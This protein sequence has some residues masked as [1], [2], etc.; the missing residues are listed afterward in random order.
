MINNINNNKIVVFDLDETLGSFVELGIFWDA[1]ENFYGHKMSNDDF[2]TLLD[3]FIEFLRPDII[4]ILKFIINKRNSGECNK[5]M[6]YTNNQAPK[7]WTKLICNYFDKKLNTIVFDKIISAFKVNGKVV[8]ICRKSHNKTFG[9]LINCSK[10]PKNT[11]IFFI[12]DQLHPD[13][14]HENVYYIKIKPYNYSLPY[15]IMAE[16]YYEYEYNNINKVSNKTEF[17][18][19]IIKIMN[20]YNYIHKDINSNE[21]D[22]IVSKQIMNYLKEFFL[23]KKHNTLKKKVIKLKKNKT[24]KIKII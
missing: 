13:M 18:D 1:L 7:S 11:K 5:I 21:I 19:T 15:N 8:E 12:D 24:K 23:K 4:N 20:R 9:D 2:I 6:I 17:I 14:E 10:I 22:K 3:I 16:K